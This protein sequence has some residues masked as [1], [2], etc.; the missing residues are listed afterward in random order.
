MFLFF[1]IILFAWS[2]FYKNS[3]GIST[4]FSLSRGH[5]SLLLHFHWLTLI[6]SRLTCCLPHTNVTQTLFNK[7][8]FNINCNKNRLETENIF[9]R[10]ES[11]VT[12]TKNDNKKVRV[13]GLKPEAVGNRK[14]IFLLGLI[15]SVSFSPVHTTTHIRIENAL[16]PYTLLHSSSITFLATSCPTRH[17]AKV[18]PSLF[19]N[20]LAS[21]FWRASTE[22]FYSHSARS[23]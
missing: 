9:L 16:K 13:G 8:N 14:H 2:T 10:K 7:V 12:E 6:W 5:G 15:D 18:C 3:T 22:S 4:F 21:R 23:W 17:H 19:Q 20:R 11:I 1:E